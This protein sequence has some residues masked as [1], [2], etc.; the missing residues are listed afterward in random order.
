MLSLAI[1]HI[2]IPKQTSPVLPPL[3]RAQIGSLGV[4]S[5]SAIQGSNFANNLCQS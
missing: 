1:R 3:R 5:F 2:P 4:S